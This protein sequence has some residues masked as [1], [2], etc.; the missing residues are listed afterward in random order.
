MKMRGGYDEAEVIAVSSD[1][2]E[3]IAFSDREVEMDVSVEPTAPASASCSNEN[4]AAS[5]FTWYCK[6]DKNWEAYPAHI[7]RLLEIEYQHVLQGTPAV[8]GVVPYE[9]SKKYNYEIDVRTMQQKNIETGK[10]RDIKRVASS[11]SP[12]RMVARQADAMDSVMVRSKRSTG[13]KNKKGSTGKWW[14]PSGTQVLSL[15]EAA[16]GYREITFLPSM[17]CCEDNAGRPLMKWPLAKGYI[18]SRN[19]IT[20][21]AW[22]IEKQRGLEKLALM[23]VDAGVWGSRR[24]SQRGLESLA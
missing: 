12:I 6:A 13:K 18:K 24:K 9:W 21:E 20:E 4:P 7:C 23:D 17:T 16:K 22:E 1:S 5:T 14:L 3:Q 2:E 10:T 15:G 8:G 19:L 11:Q